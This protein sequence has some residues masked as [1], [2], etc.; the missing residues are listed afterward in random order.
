MK[1]GKKGGLSSQK[2]KGREGQQGEKR[3]EGRK[4]FIS[5]ASW[6]LCSWSR[7]PRFGIVDP[8]HVA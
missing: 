8:W 4:G 2:E 5:L 7:E 6:K 1:A 3:Q